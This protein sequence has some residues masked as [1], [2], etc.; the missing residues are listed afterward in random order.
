M[1]FNKDLGKV[2]ITTHGDWS[3]TAEY[4][5]LSLVN[6]N[7]GT[8]LSRI[9]NKNVD[10]D[11]S[12]ETWMPIALGT[13]GAS[14]GSLSGSI[15]VEP[16][17]GMLYWTVNG[18]WLLD[19]RG[20]KVRAQ[21]ID[22]EPG[23]PGT[24]GHSPTIEIRNDYWYIDGVNTG[25]KA[26][27]EDG[28][29]TPSTATTSSASFK[30]VVFARTPGTPSAPSTDDGSYS[31]PTPTRKYTD[32][33]GNEFYWN[34]GAPSGS[35]DI[36]LWMSTRIFTSD[37]SAPQQPAWTAPER[38]MDNNSIDYEFS[39]EANPGTPETQPGYWSNEPDENTIWMA[40]RKTSNGTWGQWSVVRIKGEKG[41]DGQPGQPGAA[42]STTKSVNLF[43][44]TNEDISSV[45]FQGGNFQN[46]RPTFYSNHAGDALNLDWTDGAPDGEEQLWMITAIF[47]SDRNYTTNVQ[48]W[49]QPVRISD[50]QY[51]DYEF[52][53]GTSNGSSYP[54]I[55]KSSP[56]AQSQ[57]GWYNEARSTTVYMAMRPVKNGAYA[58][59]SSWSVVRIKGEQGIQGVPGSRGADGTSVTILGSKNDSSEL[60]TPFAGSVGS[61]YLINGNLWVWDGDSWENCG[62]IQGPRGKSVFVRFSNT[63]GTPKVFT[64]GNVPGK[65]IGIYVG[66][67]ASNSPGDYIWSLW[68]GS[69][70][71]GVE[72]VYCRT[73]G[74]TAPEVP[75]EDSTT[76]AYQQDGHVPA[77]GAVA[78]TADPVSVNADYPYLWYIFRRKNAAGVWQDWEGDANGNAVLMGHYG[79]DGYGDADIQYLLNLF[80]NNVNSAYGALLRSLIGVVDGNNTLR[81]MLNASDV[82]RDNT[83]GRLLFAAG[84]NGIENA[85]NAPFK[86]Y[87]DGT[88]R[89][90]GFDIKFG[91]EV[92][93]IEILNWYLEAFHSNG[94]ADTGYLYL[95]GDGLE[96]TFNGERNQD[97]NFKVRIGRILDENDEVRSPMYAESTDPAVPAAEFNGGQDGYA[98]HT[99]GRNLLNGL[100]STGGLRPGFRAIS[101]SGNVNLSVNSDHTLFVSVA[102][103]SAYLNLPQDAAL[104]TEFEIIADSACYLAFPVG[105]RYFQQT[106]STGWLVTTEQNSS[107]Y[108]MKGKTY[109]VICVGVSGAQAARRRQWYIIPLN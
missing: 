62:S 108:L 57:E 105:D 95:G 91:R 79:K 70:G 10:P 17:N 81:A 98:L 54:P 90:G 40:V 24:P 5:K 63:E 51:M 56:S 41:G 14:G 59:G 104:G 97:D 25:V 85:A 93:N 9:A 87:E 55:T 13:G 23:I 30:S 75:N 49:S 106:Q 107:I 43:C 83:H 50:N 80:G 26:K 89:L 68:D 61:A 76:A 53:D 27:G 32:G 82:G 28:T 100:V 4:E 102:N 3:P 48:V 64:T 103:N 33:Q 20:N 21:G 35:V 15:G 66:E 31:N 47:A 65:Y 7:G 73:E 92:G 88:G 77:G 19:S 38:V 94:Y 84:V 101:T 52:S 8:Y 36:P 39:S 29:S 58:P 86:I 109:K 72:Y 44:R 69:D 60:P 99:V 96:G 46:P 34:D 18:Q 45:V 12:P 16:F 78:W 6:R 22:G 11:G 71:F 74:S 67:T 42:G 37:G 1:D 2:G